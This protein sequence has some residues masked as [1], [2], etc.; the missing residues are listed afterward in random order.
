M[1]EHLNARG[2]TRCQVIVNVKLLGLF[3]RATF[4]DPKLLAADQQADSGLG[5]VH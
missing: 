5:V 2:G 1:L 4:R 3:Q